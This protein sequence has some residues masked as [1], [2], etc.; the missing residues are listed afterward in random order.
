MENEKPSTSM[1]VPL[2]DKDSIGSHSSLNS[3]QLTTNIIKDND[4]SN[5]SEGLNL[6]NSNL[7]QEEVYKMSSDIKFLL[8][9]VEDVKSSVNNII[10]R[11]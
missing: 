7:I 6:E 9:E 5:E 2:P 10:C 4:S 3:L 11:I 1:M 8:K